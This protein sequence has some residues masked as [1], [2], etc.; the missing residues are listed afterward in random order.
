M[1]QNV[2]LLTNQYYSPHTTHFCTDSLVLLV[3]L[4]GS[5]CLHELCLGN[6]VSFSLP[7][8]PE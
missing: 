1:N 5:V 7:V 2:S 3:G 4:A 6:E 8:S